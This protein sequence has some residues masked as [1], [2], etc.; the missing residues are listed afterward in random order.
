MNAMRFIPIIRLV[1]G[2]LVALIGFECAVASAKTPATLTPIPFG[3]NQVELLCGTNVITVFTYKPKSYRDGPLLVIFHGRTRNAEEYRDYAISLAD[4]LNAIVAVPL[5]D[6]ERY[7]IHVYTL[8]G[9]IENDTVQP[10]EKWFFPCVRSIVD[11]LRRHEGKAALDYFLV[12]HSAGGQMLMRLAAIHPM[13]AK[14]IVVANPGSD[15]FPRRD[16]EFGYGFGG[17]PVELSD[18]AA[19]QR[20]LAA[21]L[22]LYLGTADILTD[23]D[24]LDRSEGAMRQGTHRLERGRAC[25]GFAESLARERGWK[26]NWRKVETAGIG[27]DGKG[28]LAAKEVEDALFS[29]GK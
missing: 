16:W 8:G 5:F 3:T 17:L 15:L 9:V 29:A 14:R 27:H 12:G 6:Q 20:Y 1:V 24:N 2:C 23:Q 26:F 19:L 7:P 28:M 10:R 25:F 4:Q 13:D 11:E 21:P 22:T 18:D